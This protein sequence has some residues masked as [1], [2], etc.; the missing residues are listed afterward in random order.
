M[1]RLKLGMRTT[2]CRT[3]SMTHQCVVC[4][5]SISP[6]MVRAH[7]ETFKTNDF[8]SCGVRHRSQIAWRVCAWSH[9]SCST[10]EAA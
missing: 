4:D 2:E 3:T 6:Q 10:K 1:N 8:T 7:F 5:E 9:L